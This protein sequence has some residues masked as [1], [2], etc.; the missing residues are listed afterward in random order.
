[1]NNFRGY[2]PQIQEVLDFVHPG[3]SP[4]VKKSICDSVYKE[5]DR[6]FFLDEIERRYKELVKLRD[7][8][9]IFYDYS[10]NL[11]LAKE[12]LS[13]SRRFNIPFENKFKDDVNPQTQKLL[14]KT[15]L[16]MKHGRTLTVVSP[17]SGPVVVNAGKIRLSDKVTTSYSSL[18]KKKKVVC[19]KMESNS[20]TKAPAVNNVAFLEI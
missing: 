6:S 12:F 20:S 9:G 4:E 11:I 8:L 2:I 13:T 16:F 15:N 7:S 14:K 1:V 5:D 18:S 3:L 10:H 17:K 19:V